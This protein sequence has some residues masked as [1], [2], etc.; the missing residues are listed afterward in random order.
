MGLLGW[1]KNGGPLD[2]DR[3]GSSVKG[4]LKEIGKLYLKIPHLRGCQ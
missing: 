4:N 2:T 1:G 3:E